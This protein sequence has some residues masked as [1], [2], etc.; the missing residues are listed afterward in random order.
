ML[1]MNKEN[2]AKMPE[3]CWKVVAYSCTWAWAIYIMCA[4]SD[5][6]FQPD[7]SW[8]GKTTCIIV[9]KVCISHSVC[10]CVCVSLRLEARP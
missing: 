9:H 4:H 10:V 8:S 5:I 6:F 7:A 1:E 2:A 3:S